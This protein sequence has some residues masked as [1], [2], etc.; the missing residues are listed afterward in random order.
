MEDWK[1]KYCRLGSSY[2]TGTRDGGITGLRCSFST[3]VD[4]MYDDEYEGTK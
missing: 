4:D 3:H 2:I 1:L